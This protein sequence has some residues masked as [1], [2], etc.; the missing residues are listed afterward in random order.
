MS[1]WKKDCTTSSSPEGDWLADW[2]DLPVG[3]DAD[4]SGEDADACAVV[5]EGAE[6]A[7]VVHGA[8]RVGQRQPGAVTAGL[9]RGDHDLRAVVG[10]GAVQLGGGAVGGG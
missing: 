6:Q 1:V 7:G 4:G 2:L 3:D 5:A 9:Q 8:D 10:L